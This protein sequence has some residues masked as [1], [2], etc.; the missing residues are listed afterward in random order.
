MQIQSSRVRTGSA[1]NRLQMAAQVMNRKSTRSAHSKRRKD[2]E[3]SREDRV[4]LSPANQMQK[5]LDFLME[6]K[7]ELIER[8][9]EIMSSGLDTE[10]IQ[11]IVALYEEQ[12][13]NVETEIS[14]TMKQMVE[15]QLEKAEEEKEDG[16]EPET[17]EEQQIQHLNS[18]SNASMDYKQAN[19][20]HKAHDQKERDASVM[21][22]EVKLDDKRGGASQGKRERLADVLDE[23]DR[24]YTRAMEG[25]VHLNKSVND[26][27]EENVEEQRALKDKEE[28]EGGRASG[29]REKE[30]DTAEDGA[31]E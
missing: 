18:L 10:S 26:M 2:G 7:Q 13:S 17:K 28:R 15:E 19:Q 30:Q 9:N 16:K 11:S 31:E 27:E 1:G 3:G 23:A 12:I 21:S 25:Y 29:L 4:Q 6:R 8:K 5:R 24:L 20:V 22:M 14:Q